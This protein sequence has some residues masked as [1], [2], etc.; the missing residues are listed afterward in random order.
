[1]LQARRETRGACRSPCLLLGPH[2]RLRPHLRRP[3][4]P[5]CFPTQARPP[6][7]RPFPLLLRLFPLWVLW[8]LLSQVQASY[9]S[10]NKS[11]IE[12]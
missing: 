5:L 8:S 7:D 10:K 4:R 1:M 9:K 3:I 11:K 6:L 12:T 2:T